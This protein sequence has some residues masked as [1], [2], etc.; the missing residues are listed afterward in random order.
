MSPTVVILAAG[1]GSRYGGLKQLE[2]FGPNGETIMDYALHDALRAGFGKVVF[3][4]RHDFEADFRAAVGGKY[5]GRVAVEYA[6]QEIG[7]LP[8]GFVARGDRGKPWGTAHA[9][10]CAR[11]CVRE[12]FASLNADDYYGKSAF[13]AVAQHLR[14]PHD[15]APPE[16]CMVGYPIMQT[17]SEHGA[18]ARA[19]CQV[20]GNGLLQGLVERLRVEK[21]GRTA[22][23][24]DDAGTAHELAGG[25]LVSMNIFGFLPSVFDQ[26]EAQLARFLTTQRRASDSAECLIPVVVDR[27]VREGATRMR[28]LPTSDRWFGVTHANDK[29]GVMETIRAMVRRGDYP[30]PIWNNG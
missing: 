16:Y 13:V 15:G 4:I 1:M 3:V 18:V 26:L 6:F 22:R 5:E 7:D 27:L 9:I 21:F 20:D 14:Q 19:I 12:P 23:Y 30:S 11:R 29:P 10:W 2:A 28:V 24:L 17:L 8:P 25:E